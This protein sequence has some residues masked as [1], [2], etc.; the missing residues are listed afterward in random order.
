MREFSIETFARESLP[1]LLPIWNESLVRCETSVT[2][3]RD[4]FASRARAPARTHACRGFACAGA[5]HSHSYQL[6]VRHRRFFVEAVLGPVAQV[7][8]SL[9]PRFTAIGA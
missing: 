4:L 8:S 5:L 9:L 6:G 7:F 1:G 2:I 3:G